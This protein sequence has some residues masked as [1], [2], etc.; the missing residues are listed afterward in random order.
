MLGGKR[1][2]GKLL[3]NSRAVSAKLKLANRFSEQE[4]ERVAQAGR[5]IR[6]SAQL[7]AVQCPDQSGNNQVIYADSCPRPF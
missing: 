1:S 3:A 4:K 6:P 7:D 5:K 2:A